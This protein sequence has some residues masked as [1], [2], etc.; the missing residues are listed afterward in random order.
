MSQVILPDNFSVDGLSAIDRRRL[1]YY[2]EHYVL[3]RSYLYGDGHFILACYAA[4]PVV[5]TPDLVYKLWLNFKSYWWQGK[6]AVIHPV[7]PADL[8]LSPL[9]EEIG[10]E[11]YEMPEK[12]REGLLLHL[13]EIA[14]AP[15][16]NPRQLYSLTEISRFLHSYAHYDFTPANANDVAFR[17]AQ[18]WTALSYLDPGQAFGELVRKFQK[19]NNRA[20]RLRYSNALD[21]M[22]GRFLLEVVEKSS[23]I[24]T[25]HKAVTA[26]TSVIKDVFNDQQPVKLAELQRQLQH[27]DVLLTD[28]PSVQDNVINIE[29]AESVTEHL[30]SQPQKRRQRTLRAL[31]VGVARTNAPSK[32]NNTHDKE[33]A[34]LLAELLRNHPVN[35]EQEDK[36]LLV[37]GNN[38]T[39]QVILN[40]WSEV[41]ESA[42]EADDLLFYL[43]A[44]AVADDEHCCVVCSDTVDKGDKK[45]L[46]ID[47]EIGRMANNKQV[48]SITMIIQTDHAATRFW[49][50]TSKDG[51]VVFAASKYDQRPMFFPAN[52]GNGKSVCAFTY[53]LVEAL[54]N[55]NMRITNRALFIQ[56]LY[57]YDK[58]L[59][60]NINW[61][62][63]RSPVLLCN[64]NSYDLFFT[65]GNNSRVKLQTLLRDM[66][67]YNK[68]ITGDWDEDTAVAFRRYM[69][70]ANRLDN[71]TKQEYIKMLDEQKKLRFNNKPVFLLIFCD[72]GKGLMEMEKERG[73]IMDILS[74]PKMSDQ[75][76]LMV[77]QDPKGDAVREHFINP[78]YRSRIQLVY[79]SGYDRNG[80]FLLQDGA[81]SLTDFTSL[82]DYQQNIQLF[83]SNTCRS[84]YFADYV[85]M[86]GVP[87]AIGVKD[88]ITDSDGSQFG[89]LLFKT[90]I[91]G[92]RLEELPELARSYASRKNGFVL[93]RKYPME[94]LP[95]DFNTSPQTE[96][97]ATIFVARNGFPSYDKNIIGREALLQQI[98][99]QLSAQRPLLLS[100]VAGMGKTIAGIAYC[101]NEQYTSKYK[102]VIW[103]DAREGMLDGIR[104]ALDTIP[105]NE[106]LTDFEL[107]RL[108]N[109]PGNN[110][111]V[112][113]N[114]ND[115]VDLTEFIRSWISHEMNTKCLVLTRCDMGM[116]ESIKIDPLALSDAYLVFRQTYKGAFQEQDF[117]ELFNHIDWNLLI[118]EV[119]AGISNR[120]KSDD[121]V[122][123]ILLSLRSNG[124]GFLRD[125][126]KN[127]GFELIM[128]SYNP[129]NVASEEEELLRQLSLFPAREFSRQLFFSILGEHRASH[130]DA[131]SSK[132]WLERTE[133]AFQIPFIVKEICRYV[134][135]PD[136]EN[137]SQLVVR[138]NAMLNDMPGE[139]RHDLLT[140]TASVAK[141]IGFSGYEKH[142]PE[143]ERFRLVLAKLLLNDE[144]YSEGI[145]V[146]TRTDLLSA[147][148]RSV[149]EQVEALLV[150]ADLYYKNGDRHKNFEYLYECCDLL[151]E[152]LNEDS[153][154]VEYG[155]KL[156]SIRRKIA[157]LHHETNL[158]VS[159]NEY[160]NALSVAIELQEGHGNSDKVKKALA[161]C[162]MDLGRITMDID[163]HRGALDYFDES[164]SFFHEVSLM[165]G[166]RATIATLEDLIKRTRELREKN[167]Q[168]GFQLEEPVASY[169]EADVERRINVKEGIEEAF[170]VDRTLVFLTRNVT[171]QQRH[172]VLNS[173]LLAQLAA[174]KQFPEIT[175]AVEWN[176][177][178]LGVFEKLG[179]MVE[180][181]AFNQFNSRQPTFEIIDAITEVWFS[182]YGASSVTLLKKGLAAVQSIDK[183]SSVARAFEKNT[184]SETNAAF[185]VCL[186]SGQNETVVL[187][188]GMFVLES[189]S[190]IKEMLRTRSS[191]DNLLLHYA[192]SRSSINQD[193]YEQIRNA[194]KDKLQGL[195]GNYIAGI[196]VDSPS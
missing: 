115:L 110:L 36:I 196:D 64:N 17:E 152:Q 61:R 169:F 57:N 7:A 65:Q 144:R 75:V 130:M 153:W 188:T 154:A 139:Y 8:L 55:Q 67:L 106:N 189:G 145:E 33:S 43:A 29:V 101:K 51:N 171:E 66:G 146:I 91:S 170:I 177:S 181:D 187:E 85:S 114:A 95:W 21:K 174:H 9:V 40:A 69:R 14:R 162:Y 92:G 185:Q 19:A 37:A 120:S 113:D 155:L 102:H 5:L 122:T 137:C 3:R 186:V 15:E 164:L 159:L 27:P 163:D 52:T 73:Y 116:K 54:Q 90:I 156:I 68:E 84:E 87:Q 35:G 26:L 70:T 99:E 148:H 107:V 103:A 183:K 149:D 123:Q 179:F 134:L 25:A 98:D 42:S 58:V 160:K 157:E 132:G 47:E 166:V 141:E 11:L 96:N 74:A 30:G 24:P 151:R 82:L 4:L 97:A 80:D 32:Q 49:L 60:S 192:T 94:V 121:V 20:E 88:E 89:M 128:N 38:A 190:Q 46:L 150:A 184:H 176:R 136:M 1:G 108:R 105:G 133:P 109:L 16:T 119:L 165:D 22:S 180:K 76:E 178:C 18:I 13:A 44:D 31:V 131:L 62:A 158:G 39:K 172:D 28:E 191:G 195:K 112:I 147:E 2:Y 182:V 143:Y 83:V 34:E 86:L 71:P 118:L 161:E 140:I 48:A 117:N 6:Y 53:A 100:G 77:L 138:L 173:L 168:V 104:R 175:Q 111:L 72:P 194:I 50:D 126:P 167:E 129:Y 45:S 63:R 142:W 23:L 79:Y 81:F 12:I 59:E 127:T 93:Y 135:T 41:I 124:L 125:Y 10:H 56:S 78:E 193:Y